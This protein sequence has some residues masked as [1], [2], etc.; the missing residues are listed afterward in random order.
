MLRYIYGDELHTVPTL[1]DT[2]FRDRAAQ[3]KD[4]LNW[5]VRVDADGFERD[6]YDAM[7]PLYAIWERADGTHGGSMRFLPTVADTMVNDHFTHLT[8]GV[9][10]QSPMIWECTRFCQAAD[11]EGRV[12][13]LLMLAALEIGCGFH[14]SD[15]V[16]VFDARMVRI[17]RRLGWE[18]TVLGS[19]GTGRDAISVGLWECDAGL[20]ETL[21]RR[22]GVTAQMAD[23]WFDRAF[24][25][26]PTQM[27]MTG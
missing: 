15:L 4:R 10:I 17:Y 9:Q 3:F 11:A 1:R 24:G 20:R 6:A 14:L 26:I 2:M 27:A 23:H 22:A 12:S 13:A 19:D 18:P 5:E 8:D 21:L 16:G 25:A 7:N